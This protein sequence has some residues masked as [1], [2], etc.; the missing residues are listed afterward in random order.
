M[1]GC[2]ETTDHPMGVLTQVE[3]EGPCCTLGYR[4]SGAGLPEGAPAAATAV[5]MEEEPE[6]CLM[7]LSNSVCRLLELDC[8]FRRHQAQAR[9]MM[10]PSASMEKSPRPFPN[11]AQ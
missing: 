10:A 8:F 6:A 2:P 5:G 4:A 9:Q 7:V 1:G 11:E 3:P